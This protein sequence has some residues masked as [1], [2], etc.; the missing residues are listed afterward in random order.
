M[1]QQIAIHSMTEPGTS[2]TGAPATGSGRPDHDDRLD[3]GAGGQLAADLADQ[4]AFHEAA[5]PGLAGRDQDDVPHTP[6][7]RATRAMVLPGRRVAATWPQPSSP[8]RCEAARALASPTQLARLP[9]RFLSV[10]VFSGEA[11]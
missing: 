6:R 11:G 3:R 2:A 1:R 7:A 8:A 5:P 10:T 4:V 9:I